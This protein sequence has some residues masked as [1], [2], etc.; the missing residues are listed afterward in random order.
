MNMSVCLF[1]CL[2]VRSHKSNTKC[3]YMLPIVLGPGGVFWHADR[4][5]C[6]QQSTDDRRQFI[7]LCDYGLRYIPAKWSTIS[8]LAELDVE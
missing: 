3:L 1:D 4:H 6:C 7:T 5:E 2:S 8:V